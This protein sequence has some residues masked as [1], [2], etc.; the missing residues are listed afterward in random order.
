MKKLIVF[1]IS[2]IAIVA[3]LFCAG[4]GQAWP[5]NFYSTVQGLRSAAADAPGTFIYQGNGLYLVA[6]PQ[7]KGYA[8]SVI[9]QA[10]DVTQSLVKQANAT[11]TTIYTMSDL[12]KWV[13]SQGWTRVLGQDLPP[14]IGQT[15]LGYTLASV[16]SGSRAL[17]TV[18][19]FPA[20]T[21]NIEDMDL[22]HQ[23][24]NQ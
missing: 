1:S 12:V 15:L 10:G 20:G 17:V 19:A 6:W 11:G 8:F 14:Q 7:A 9:S 21:L 3:A 24:S 4:G 23:R 13:E 22:T 2:I 5:I 18:L 16:A